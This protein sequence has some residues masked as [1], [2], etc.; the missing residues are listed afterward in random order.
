MDHESTLLR[1]VYIGMAAI[2]GAIVSLSLMPWQKMTKGERGMA[3]FV[4]T[5][6]ALF[7]V[8]WIVGSLMNVDITPLRVAC[9][10]TFVGAVGAPS[11]IPRLV[12]FIN[13]KFGLEEPGK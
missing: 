11:F 1:Y 3:I 6:F 10:I 9:G 7:G 2:S 12:Q 5:A 13:K 4:G 8:P